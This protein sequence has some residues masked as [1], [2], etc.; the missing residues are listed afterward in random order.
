MSISPISSTSAKKLDI[1]QPTESVSHN[2]A[3]KGFA[4]GQQ[5]QQR[6][7]PQSVRVVALDP[8][9]AALGPPLQTAVPQR[10]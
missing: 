2:V 7:T 8:L 10:A 5:I 3:T 1:P 6:P 9:A 4:Q